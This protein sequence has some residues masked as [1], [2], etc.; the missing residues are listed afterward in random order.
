MTG[1]SSETVQS[2]FVKE[3]RW[4]EESGTIV[5]QKPYSIE[6]LGRT[7]LEVLEHASRK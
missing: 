1:Y 3:S 2:R 7:V 4:I 5:V 6:G